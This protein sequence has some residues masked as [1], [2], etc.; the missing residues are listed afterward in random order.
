M[1]CI[2]SFEQLF[3]FKAVTL[4]IL[5]YAK[6]FLCTFFCTYKCK[7]F[8]NCQSNK[9]FLLIGRLFTVVKVG[10]LVMS[11][12]DVP[13]LLSR[14]IFSTIFLKNHGRGEI[15]MT[16]TSHRTVVVGRQGHATC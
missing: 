1:L 6:T 10:E 14:A 16:A 8:I 11:F 5:L 9:A 2:I 15:L 13:F 3:I 7:I 4:K 12:Q